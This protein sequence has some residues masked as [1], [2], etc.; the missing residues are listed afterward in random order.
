MNAPVTTVHLPAD[1][2]SGHHVETMMT[3]FDEKLTAEQRDDP[4]FAFRVFMIP[5]TANRAPGSDLAVEIVTPG[6]EIAKSFA[7][8]LKEIEKKKFLPGEIVKTMKAEGFRRFTMNCHTKL[9]Q[10][11]RAKD[12]SKGYGAIAVGNQWCW[13]E[14]WLKRVR[15]ECERN[16]NKYG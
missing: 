4:R 2:R 9:W 6:S 12:P 1:L 14:T 11:M 15:E 10:E 8:A 3:A 7:I 16:R 13:Y 5:K